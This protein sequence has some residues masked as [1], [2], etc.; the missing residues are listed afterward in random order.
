[1]TTLSHTMRVPLVGGALAASL[2]LA[3]CTAPA[4]SATTPA[5][6]A[7]SSGSVSVANLLQ[8]GIAAA[9]S[10]DTA[11]ATA[12]FKTVL[13][14]D[15]GNALANYNLGV[16]A[17]QAGD[18]ASAMKFYDAALKTDPNFTSAMYN[19]AIILE[20]T[21]PNAAIGLYQKIVGIN[22]KAAT[23]FYRL[24]VL[25]EKKGDKAGAKDARDQAIALDPS[26]ASQ[27]GSGG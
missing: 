27:P 22:P 7:S 17:H 16:L 3:G 21:D 10:G 26:L 1:M 18:T 20:A 25:L 24:S 19:K 15:P 6:Q 2:L 14:V 11:Q 4:P 9:Q 13:A 8:L 12:T 23:A 5:P